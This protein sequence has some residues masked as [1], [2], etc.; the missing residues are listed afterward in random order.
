MTK[1]SRNSMDKL[2]GEKS[3][4]LPLRCTSANLNKL[5][6]GINFLIIGIVHPSESTAVVE[7]YKAIY[8]VYSLTETWN[9]NRLPRYLATCNFQRK[10]GAKK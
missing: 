1:F 9:C 6:G 2:H 8:Y 4:N 7:M 5:S 3:I 10:D